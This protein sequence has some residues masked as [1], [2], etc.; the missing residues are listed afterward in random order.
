VT[1]C[2]GSVPKRPIAW[3]RYL[4]V[5][6]V[7][8]WMFVLGVLVGRGTAPV[9]FDTQALQK[10]LAALRDAMMKKERD[11]LEKA[12]RGEDKK[13]PLE[14]YEA[15]KKDDPDTTVELPAAQASTDRPSAP[16]E[17]AEAVTLP[18]KS[19]PPLMAKKARLTVNPTVKDAPPATPAAMTA[20]GN[21]T[22]QVASLKDPTAAQ[23]IVANLKK[24]GYA[25]YLSRIV[26]PG[27]GLWFR[28]RVGSYK[29]R[30]QASADMA[31]LARELRNPILVKK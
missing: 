9:Q 20:T 2:K 26:I 16:V 30:E 7:A 3:G 1:E 17:R 22:I 24:D 28:V 25:A 5:F 13:A 12:I 19:R 27:K 10:E 8:A 11:A 15:L 6:F 18:H 21:L 23:R 4:L 31:R 14:F 29:G